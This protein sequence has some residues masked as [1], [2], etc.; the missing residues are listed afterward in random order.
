MY[1]LNHTIRALQAVRKVVS[2]RMGGGGGGGGE[3]FML[4]MGEARRSRC[5]RFKYSYTY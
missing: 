1:F 5:E 2:Y 3:R 4:E